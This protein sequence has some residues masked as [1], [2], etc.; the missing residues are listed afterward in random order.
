M[1][2]EFIAQ[3]SLVLG[4]SA[5][6][7]SPNS[8]AQA[9]LCSGSVYVRPTPRPAITLLERMFHRQKAAA[10]RLQPPL[11][12]SRTLSDQY[13]APVRPGSYL[14]SLFWSARFTRIRRMP[15]PVDGDECV[16]GAGIR[17]RGGEAMNRA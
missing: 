5:S 14:R 7:F 9:S 2:L 15:R 11:F 3:N 1:R 6:L 12:R 13:L 4:L 10:N 16:G 8:S 17:N